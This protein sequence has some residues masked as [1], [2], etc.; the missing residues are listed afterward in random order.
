[1]K[2]EVSKR[3]AE[4]D[5]NTF[6]SFNFTDQRE[7]IKVTTD[8]GNGELIEEDSLADEETG[9]NAFSRNGYKEF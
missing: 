3:W 6:F 4:D 7:A 2:V 1:M 5:L 9:S 8:Y